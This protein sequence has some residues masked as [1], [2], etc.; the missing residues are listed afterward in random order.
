MVN[1]QMV[2][3][4]KVMLEFLKAGAWGTKAHSL[5]LSPLFISEV[6]QKNEFC[7]DDNSLDGNY[8]PLV[9]SAF[10]PTKIN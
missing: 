4:F 3:F 5:F 9:Y 10:V 6:F 8:Y 1:G 7:Y 2:N